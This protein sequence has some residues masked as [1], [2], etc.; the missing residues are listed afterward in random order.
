MEGPILTNPYIGQTCV[1]CENVDIDACA[2]NVSLIEKLKAQLSSLEVKANQHTRRWEAQVCKRC[3]LELD[4]QISRMALVSTKR[5]NTTKGWKSMGMSSQNS[6]RKVP[7]KRSKRW[8]WRREKQLT[9]LILLLNLIFMPLNCL[10]CL[11]VW[12]MH[13]VSVLVQRG[14]SGPSARDSRVQSCYHV[15]KFFQCILCLI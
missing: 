9:T 5:L 6:L 15:T 12:M 14:T 3:I 11:D 2:T 1:R 10:K 7:I 13:L 4:I 8:R